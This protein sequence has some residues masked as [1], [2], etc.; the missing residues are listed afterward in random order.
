M[1]RIA[2][3]LEVENFD[4]ANGFVAAEMQILG[5]GVQRHCGRINQTGKGASGTGTGFANRIAIQTLACLNG[6]FRPGTGSQIIG[7]TTI[8]NIHRNLR[9][10]ECGTA[11]QK[12]DGIVF[13][14]IHELAQIGNDLLIDT[15]VDLATVTHFHHTTTGT[16]PVGQFFPHLLQHSQRN[17]GGTCS[18]IPMTHLF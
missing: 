12:Q 5:L 11:L 1:H 13:R 8:Q 9:K 6:F 17:G 7:R 15:R 4:T 18:K 14:D 10:L 3:L 2:Q 16:V